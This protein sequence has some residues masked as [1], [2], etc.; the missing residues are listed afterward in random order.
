M[1]ALRLKELLLDVLFAYTRFEGRGDEKRLRGD[2]RA[3]P[4]SCFVFRVRHTVHA[5]V[6]MRGRVTPR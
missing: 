5:R 4:S 3:L 2:W 6:N 1:H